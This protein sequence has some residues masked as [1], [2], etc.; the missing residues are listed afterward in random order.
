METIDIKRMADKLNIHTNILIVKFMHTFLDYYVSLLLVM[1]MILNRVPS[2][3]CH[4]VIPVVLHS[5]IV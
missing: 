5:S 4:H 2:L 1:V 3:L